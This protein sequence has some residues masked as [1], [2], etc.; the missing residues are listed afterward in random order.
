MNTENTNS[1]KTETQLIYLLLHH[2]D[3]LDEFSKTEITADY[4]DVEYQPLITAIIETYQK[5]KSLLTKKCFDAYKK[6]FTIQQKIALDVAFG[7]CW[8]EK[9]NPENFNLLL[10]KV[11]ENFEQTKD[12]SI[13]NEQINSLNSTFQKFKKGEIDKSELYPSLTAAI[14]KTK[15]TTTQLEKFEQLYYP[16]LSVPVDCLPKVC[17]D[18]IETYTDVLTIPADYI[19]LPILAAI[20]SA[21]GKYYRFYAENSN[22]VRYPNIWTAIVG[23]PGL[24][25]T[26]AL[27]DVIS[28]IRIRDRELAALYTRAVKAYQREYDLW[29]QNKNHNHNPKPTPPVQHQHTFDQTTIQNF[30]RVLRDNPR[31]LL[32]YQDEISKFIKKM[33]TD[34]DGSLETFLEIHTYGDVDYCIKGNSASF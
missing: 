14:E 3:R 24:K 20:G 9:T 32:L 11:K 19:A 31:G 8:A 25:K 34:A 12:L 4:F 29:E 30:F 13:V 18:Y 28:P 26:T 27:S 33:I 23:E 17:R 10:D 16:K 21:A 1:K 6:G 15:S 7:N 2:K 22:Y 5:Y